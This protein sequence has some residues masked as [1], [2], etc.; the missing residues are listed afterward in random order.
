MFED[1]TLID[2]VPY[3]VNPKQNVLNI[4]PRQSI[5][6]SQVIF[7]GRHEL[8][9]GVVE[10]VKAIP[11]VLNKVPN[12]HFTFVGGSSGVADNGLPMLDHLKKLFKQIQ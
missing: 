3:I 10:L 2:H 8:R 12:V 4:Q 1:E 11:K 7:I 9:K 6:T 5:A